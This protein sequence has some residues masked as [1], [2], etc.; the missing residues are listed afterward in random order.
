[1]STCCGWERRS[2]KRSECCNDS[3]VTLFRSLDIYVVLRMKTRSHGMSSGGLWMTAERFLRNGWASDDRW[4]RC[5]FWFTTWLASRVFCWQRDFE[6]RLLGL[7]RQWYARRNIPLENCLQW[8]ISQT[9]SEVGE[10]RTNPPN[11]PTYRTINPLLS[12]LSALRDSLLPRQPARRTKR[13]KR[14]SGGLTFFGFRH[15]TEEGKEKAP[16][17]RKTVSEV[18]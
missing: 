14:V 9:L 6:Y 12:S 11:H 16:T 5:S 15:K 13:K 1:M 7:V 17:N 2:R 4:R 8:A 10:T 3:R 18:C